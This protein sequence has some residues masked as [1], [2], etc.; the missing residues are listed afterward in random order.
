MHKKECILNPLLEIGLNLF[1]FPLIY[2]IIKMFQAF[3]IITSFFQIFNHNNLLV[4]NFLVKIS[5]LY[6]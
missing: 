2:Q 3:I 1:T 6:E 5:N 4:F